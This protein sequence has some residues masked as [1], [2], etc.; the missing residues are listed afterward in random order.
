MKTHL[1]TSDFDY[2][3]ADKL[4]AKYPLANRSDS[5]LLVLERATQR[6]YHTK[7][8]RFVDFI[9][10]DDLIVF[11]NTQVIPARL[12]GQ[13][14]SGGKIEALVERIL[15]ATTVLA[16]LKAS[17][18]PAIGSKIVFSK[19]LNAKVVDKKANLFMLVFESQRSILDLL[20]E[21]GQIP[22]PPYLQREAEAIDHLR[23]QTIFAKHQ[24]AV[25]APTASLHFDEET[26]AK[27]AKKN[28]ETAFVTLHV[29][30][31]TFQPVRHENFKQHTMH[32][33]YLEL[34]DQA[35]Q[36]I[37]R[38]KAR[39]G[40]VIA[41]GTTVVRTLE[42]VMQQGEIMPYQGETQLFIYPGYTFRC[43]DVMFT[44]F[45]LPK[46]TLLMLVCAFAG[47]PLVMHSYQM[48]MQQGYRFFS[49]G[50]AMLII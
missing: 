20:T 16:H 7:F 31:G 39:G 8:N 36:K 2:H 33:E 29:G 26:L 22:L 14:E 4:I 9:N 25:A 32:Q 48:A 28:I 5:R 27:I 43:V 30:A 40:R 50:D 13:K 17:K 37:K 42:T 3:L 35:C 15:S 19:V 49:Y 6:L 24:G 12:F 21:Y 11:N 18:A 38:C 41:I 47:Y 44:N 46:S 10:E 23:Y 34:S 1:S 45:H